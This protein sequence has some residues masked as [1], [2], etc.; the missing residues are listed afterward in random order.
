M[1]FNNIISNRSVL[2][3]ILISL[4]AGAIFGAGSLFVKMAVMQSD[5]LS[6]II[7][8]VSWLALILSVSGFLLLQKA[9]HKEYIS[10]VIPI[11]TGTVTLVSVI[12]AHIVLNES[13]LYT[14][15]AGIIIIIIGTF[16]ISMT[17]KVK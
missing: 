8:P 5:I 11:V 1:G 13:I 9:M 16:M 2:G 12:L 17:R 14:R 6:I 15:W 3:G 7:Y 10:V 4:I